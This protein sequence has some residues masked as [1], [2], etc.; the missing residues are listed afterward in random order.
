[1]E[2][3]EPELVILCKK[4]TTI[5]GIGLPIQQQNVIPF[6]YPLCKMFFGIGC[7]EL[8]GVAKP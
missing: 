6:I 8:M 1:M 5:D 2:D 4:G 3:T 7:A